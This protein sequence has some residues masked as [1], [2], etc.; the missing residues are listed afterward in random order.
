MAPTKGSARR[1]L[2]GLG[3]LAVMLVIGYV[4]F[5]ANQGRL[6]G[7]PVTTVRA[8]FTDVGQLQAGSE[9]RQNGITIGQV[10]AVQLVNGQPVVTMDV[11]GGVPMYR[12]G[13][14]G[15]WDQ[16]ALA[17]KFIELRAGNP[18]SGPLDDGTL[19]V[20][21][22]ESTHDLV[23]VLDVFDPPTR[24]ALG[25]ALRQ[26]GGGL[27]GYG[28]GLHGFIGSAPGVLSDVS[29]LSTTLVSDR[30]DLPGLLH[31]SDRLSSRFT[32]REYQWT[33]LLH[34]TDETL[35]ALG[36][37]NGTPLGDTLT[38]LPGTL[39][40]VRTALDDADQPLTDLASAAGDLRSGA[41]SLGRATP[42]V[43]GVF[44]EA[45]AP[46]DR[47]P[48]VSDDAKPAVADLS[49]TFS[50]AQSLTPKLAD[51]LSSAAPPL[52]VLAPYAPDLGTFAF[53]LSNLIVDHDGWEHRLRI[54]AGAPSLPTLLVNQLKDT[55]NPYPAPGQAIRDRDP[56]G[57]EIPGR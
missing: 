56:N 36:V 1:F 3:T 11:H 25:N 50:D 27:A 2:S 49:R 37:D 17:Q 40:A 32:G 34:Q 51:A 28:P 7:T 55:N 53:D 44:R 33:E 21:Q 13:Y 47:I 43:R 52:K 41:H 45:H 6:P 14:A 29:E 31:T 16:S 22:T 57:G 54:M 8:A 39:R 5:T 18:A 35:R 19:P 26:L 12:D 23:Q 48:G 30:T 46:L 15:I 42:D 20:G 4:A 38:K 24:A 10:S 9:V